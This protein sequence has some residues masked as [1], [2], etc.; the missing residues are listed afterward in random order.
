MD[1]MYKENSHR[2]F[3]N[4]RKG[5]V[6]MLL[7]YVWIFDDVNDSDYWSEYVNLCISTGR[8][9]NIDQVNTLLPVTTKGITYPEDVKRKSSIAYVESTDGTLRDAPVSSYILRIHYDKDNDI[10]WKDTAKLKVVISNLHDTYEKYG[11]PYALELLSPL[12][13]PT[14][15]EEEFF[16][17]YRLLE[18]SMKKYTNMKIV[19]VNGPQRH[20]AKFKYLM[21]STEDIIRIRNI[22]KD[23]KFKL[24]FAVNISKLIKKKNYLGDFEDDFNRLSEMRNA[25]VGI[26]LSGKLGSASFMKWR[27]KDDNLL[28]NK[29]EYPHS[30]DFLG[31]ISALLNDNLCRYFV[32]EGINNASKLEE[33]VDDLLRGGFSFRGQEG[34]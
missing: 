2:P 34:E 12:R 22:A 27:Y 25:I 21:Q 17:Q 23:M 20:N 8:V 24:K 7:M 9:S 26:H 5:E 6:E 18:K 30:S 1:E 11:V 14:Y 32:P 33:L 15:N 29:F 31:C 16:E 3:I 28:F 10:V 4:G 13:S 19:L